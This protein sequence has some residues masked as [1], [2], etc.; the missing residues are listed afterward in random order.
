[1][2]TWQ[3]KIEGLTGV[4]LDSAPAPSA[5]ETTV[6][7]ED[8]IQ[9][10]RIRLLRVVP[11]DTPQFSEIAIVT[12][13]NGIDVE[14]ALAIVS[15]TRENGTSSYDIPCVQV[16][17]SMKYKVED[18]ES[19]HFR[20]KHNPC[21]FWEKEKIYI[22]PDPNGGS[23]QRGK[24]TYV[25][26]STTQ[27]AGGAVSHA[28][29][30]EDT[31]AFPNKYLHLAVQHASANVLTATMNNIH[32]NIN[33]MISND[34]SAPDAPEIIYNDI[35]MPTLPTYN[36]PAIVLDYPKVDTYFNVE[37][38]E[39][40]TPAISKITQQISEFNARSKDE[41]QK[42]AT[43]LKEYDNELQK[44]LKGA[45]S[46]LQGDIAQYQRKIEKYQQDIAKFGAHL[47]AWTQRYQW[48]TERYTAIVQQYLAFF[49]QI[50]PSRQQPEEEQDERRGR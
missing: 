50:A 36:P 42:I 4:T 25:P 23:A 34:I 31:D 22:K 9:E 28:S 35:T 44:R 5:A 37:D 11:Q 38:T 45:E 3:Q 20:S 40:V 46:T 13:S 7:I 27:S 15:V 49:G 39:L 41:Q 12:D 18:S 21:W 6:F 32:T 33:T 17:P 48:Y 19:L 24:A 10:T 8:A 47:Q 26:S 2:S 1:M 14:E 43:Q 30:V 29:V 16:P